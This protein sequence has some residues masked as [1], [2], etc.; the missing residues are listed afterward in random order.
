ME[1]PITTT[2]HSATLGGPIG[3]HPTVLIGSIFYDRHRIVADMMRGD[4]DEVEAERLIRQQ[5]EWA[6]KTGCPAMIDV[7]GSTPEAICRYLEFVTGVS[8]SAFLVDGSSPEVRLAGMEWCA[9]NSLLD[10]AVYNSLTTESKPEEFERL[11]AVGCKSAIVLCMNTR[12]FTLKGRL[13]V[14]EGQ[15][16]Q[17]GLYQRARQAGIKNILLDP[18]IVDIPSIGTAKCFQA[19]VKETY[20]GL[21]GAAPHN[22]ISNWVGLRSKLGKDSVRTCTAVTDVLMT[23]WGGDFVIYGPIAHAPLAFPVVAMVDAALGQVQLEAGKMP[24]ISHPM[25]K[26]A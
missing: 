3:A 8:N 2:I 12:D 21:V 11:E 18:G 20:G 14:L 17:L 7:I 16:G 24:D 1:E 23:V 5:D 6:Q 10:R 13:Q 15:D 22:A 4:F 9:Q 19:Y 26:I 25:F